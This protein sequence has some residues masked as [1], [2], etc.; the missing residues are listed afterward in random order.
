MQAP[1]ILRDTAVRA[2]LVRRV[3]WT[4]V[5]LLVA[6]LLGLWPVV[7]TAIGTDRATR[8]LAAWRAPREGPPASCA[9]DIEWFVAPSRIPWTRTPASYRAEELTAREA[10]EAY[11]DATI[12]HPDH[13]AAGRAGEAVERADVAMRGGSL[14]VELQELGPAL[15]APDLGYYAYLVGDR[16]TLVRKA[17]RWTEA[18]V[19][20]RALEA[21]VEDGEDARAAAIAD[22]YAGLDP[23]DDDLRTETAAAL[24][25]FGDAKKGLGLLE[26]LQSE[27]AGI[28]HES[29]SRDFG[30]V[31][32]LILAC[33]HKAGV[34]PG[35]APKEPEAGQLDLPEARAVLRLR[36]L[37]A[38]RRPRGGGATARRGRGRDRPARRGGARA[39]SRAR[40]RSGDRLRAS[41]HAQ[42][43]VAAIARPKPKD[44]P[45][46]P[47]FTTPFDWL[48]ERPGVIPLPGYAV[49]ARAADRA[50]ELAQ[51]TDGEGVRDEL[52]ELTRALRLEAARAAV[53]ELDEAAAPP[54]VER[55]SESFGGDAARRH[56]LARR[57]S[58]RQADRRRALDEI[59]AP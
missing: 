35:E 49:L 33:A 7:W 56:R 55:A 44:D 21:A 16:D 34:P 58:T 32:Y 28:H 42:R 43:I 50:A 48:E 31:R 10:I 30:D 52:R 18:R 6:L 11:M 23:H 9:A 5:V 14:R 29:F 19:R 45:L 38:W 12:G 15:A 36:A 25:S 3:G 53:A 20:L 17:E 54:F 57:R 27:R 8:C 13:A 4:L 1:A 41:A 2:R 59:E 24:C 51:K 22:H 46:A 40:R 47:V 26:Y 37:R 39:V